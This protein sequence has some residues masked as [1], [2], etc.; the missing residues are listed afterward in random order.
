MCVWLPLNSSRSI[1]VSVAVV[2]D[3][4][5]RPSPLSSTTATDRRRCRRHA[6]VDPD[7]RQRRRPPRQRSRP[8][9]DTIRNKDLR[10]FCRSGIFLNK[11]KHFQ[12]ETSKRKNTPLKHAQ[13]IM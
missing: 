2:V 3:T 7:R 9:F 1:A 5:D 4:S 13:R 6:V 11:Q 12:F 8:E 10:A